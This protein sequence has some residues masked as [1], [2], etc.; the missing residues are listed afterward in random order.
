M[1]LQ[2]FNSLAI[3]S[4]KDAVNFI[5]LLISVLPK[6][7][8]KGKAI[9]G[10]YNALSEEIKSNEKMFK[11]TFHNFFLEYKITEENSIYHD[12]FSPYWS[13]SEKE[14]VKKNNPHWKF[15]KTEFKSTHELTKSLGKY[16]NDS[17]ENIHNFITEN[18]EEIT[19]RVKSNKDNFYTHM[20][21][22]KCWETLFK[23][24][25]DFFD[26]FCTEYQYDKFN[27]VKNLIAQSDYENFEKIIKNKKTDPRS[28]EF[29]LDNPK[30]VFYEEFVNTESGDAEF[31]IVDAFLTFI[32]QEKT[33]LAYKLYDKNKKEMNKS[34]YD[35]MYSYGYTLNIDKANAKNKKTWEE[36]IEVLDRVNHHSNSAFSTFSFAIKPFRTV[37]ETIE[38]IPQILACEAKRV[39]Y[40]QMKASLDEKPSSEAKKR[41]KI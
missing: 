36:F 20:M 38:S 12:K 10:A 25:Y 5:N 11:S 15:S 9:I 35:Y 28:I 39:E 7:V 41:V 2:T 1:D 23:S 31:N 21:H 27:I 22:N 26:K 33:D 29:I 19:R 13:G 14:E 16:D 32:M 24:N 8:N 18:K 6:D 3:D 37:I 17:F 34:I 30:K 4:P 40:E